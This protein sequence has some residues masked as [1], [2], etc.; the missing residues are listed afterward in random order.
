MRIL[1]R[2]LILRMSTFNN[3]NSNW[4]ESLYGFNEFDNNGNNIVKSNMRIENDV[5]ISNI[6]NRRFPIGKFT[7]PTLLEL[8]EDTKRSISSS[9]NNS[10]SS[11]NKMKY[12]HIS[13]GDIFKW[14]SIYPDATFQCASQFNCLEFASPLMT[15]ER[16]IY[17]YTNDRTQGPAC[18][19]A[20]ASGTIYRNYFYNGEGQSFNNQINNLKNLEQLLDVQ[21][22]KN[23]YTFSSSENLNN[24]NTKLSLLDK[25]KLMECIQ[26]GVHSEV[27][28]TF[29]DR[30]IDINNQQLKV[31]QVYCSALS[32]AYNKDKIDIN[33][34][35]PLASLILD[36]C[37][38]ATILTGILT[39][40]KLQTEG[41]KHIFL[42]LIGGG[43]FGNKDEWICRA[44]AKALIIADHINE[45]IEINICHY[46][47]VDQKIVQLIE[48]YYNELK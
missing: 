24:I 46:G 22:V 16:G 34:W 12:N 30:Y 29:S 14:H 19:I 25:S 40:L 37:Y 33:L 11:T 35:E 42:T 43:V 8:R 13:S 20:C 4:F 36:T 5:L 6:N 21:I 3:N 9:N 45:D 15:P 41:S 1:K 23:G 17:C 44:I 32:I 47:Q 26:V 18:A 10:S 27:G 48:K 2:L 7:T 38:E 31:T 39:K 28:V